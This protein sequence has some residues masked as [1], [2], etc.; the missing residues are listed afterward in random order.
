MGQSFTC[1][2]VHAIFSTKNRAP[3]ITVDFQQRLYDYIGGILRKENCPL[4]AAG[5]TADHIHLLHGLHAQ[6]A[7]ADV[8]RVVKTNSSKWVHET[9]PDKRNF[10]WQD[11][12]AVFTVS[13]SNLETARRYI[14]SQEEHHRQVSF[15][16]ELIAFLKKHG[17][18]YNERYVWG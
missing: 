12:Y 13:R 18:E 15:Q 7:V 1:L 4:I 6:T 11:G 8:M 2:H 16:D 14:S 10:A 9:F 3:L 5:G 17:V